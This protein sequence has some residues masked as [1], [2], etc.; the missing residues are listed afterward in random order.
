MMIVSDAF[1]TK[2]VILLMGLFTIVYSAVTAVVWLLLVCCFPRALL[3]RLTISRAKDISKQQQ[4]QLPHLNHNQNRGDFSATVC[5]IVYFDFLS[6][7]HTHSHTHSYSFI[8][9]TM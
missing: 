6:Y 5:T 1:N 2:F 3:C 4:K 7:S 8:Q 9:F